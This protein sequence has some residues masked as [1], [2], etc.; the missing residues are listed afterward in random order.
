LLFQR[1]TYHCNLQVG[2]EAVPVLADGLGQGES[3]KQSQNSPLCVRMM[4][5]LWPT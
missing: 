3:A 5:M 1:Q 4:V 2:Q